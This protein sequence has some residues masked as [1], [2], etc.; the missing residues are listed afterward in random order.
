M[1]LHVQ[2]SDRYGACGCKYIQA[3][4]EDKSMSTTHTPDH[5]TV[6]P[7]DE[8]LAATVAALEGAWVQR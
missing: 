6:L 1:Y 2:P 5:Y 3:R 7:D 8:T 4:E